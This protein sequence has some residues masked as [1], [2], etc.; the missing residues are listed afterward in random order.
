MQVE[1]PLVPVSDIP[2]GKTFVIDGNVW[3]R[4]AAGA[5]TDPGNVRVATL[6]DGTQ[7]AGYVAEN[8][9]GTYH[10]FNIQYKAELE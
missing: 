3:I 8:L 7:A 9:P 4:L 10:V 5:A 1:S 2:Q 6:D